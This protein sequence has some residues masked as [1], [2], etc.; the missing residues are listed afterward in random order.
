MVIRVLHIFPPSLKTRFGGQNITW[1]YNFSNWDEQ[2]IQHLC[3]DLEQKVVVPGS[4]A[5][6]FTYPDEQTST[7]RW[8]RLLWILRLLFFT[9]KFK[10][11]YDILHVH[12]LWWGSLLLAN[13]A[14]HQ[15]IPTIYETVL[16]D[17]DTPGSISK[18]K[19]GGLKL[20]LLKKYTK[21]LA[22]SDYLALDYLIHGFQDNQVEVLPN[23]VDTQLFQPVSSPGQKRA[24]REKHKLPLNSKIIIFVGSVIY[25][26]GVD[27]L[28]DGYLKIIQQIDQVCLL[29][30]GPCHK[31]ENP[32]LD[33]A[34]VVAL[35]HKASKL[36]DGS[37][38][39]F[40]GI[41]NDREILSELYQSSDIFAFLSRQEGLGN[42][43]L[44]AM[45]CGLPC[46]ISDL[47]VL[48]NIISHRETGLLVPIS[49]SETFAEHVLE[50]LADLTLQEK[51]G[52][53]SR[54]FIIGHHGFS[55]W[56]SQLT[57]LYEGLINE[58]IYKL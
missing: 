56:Q 53:N 57:S 32:S 6:N 39:I 8:S 29:L 36:N 30:V 44:E 10:M 40:F 50:L 15:G 1:K 18:E 37:K 28:L 43:V 17:A 12:V 2:K 7:G 13:W 42:V 47:P 58:L 41:Q 19:L 34:F 38:V 45:A 11:D 25:R 5:F 22:I 31:Y 54:K 9:R 26:K 51:L 35:K 20:R 24:L 16:L 21:I 3:L 23:S 27:I 46:V 48:K 33:E 52:S 55:H 49:D 14:K 4:Q